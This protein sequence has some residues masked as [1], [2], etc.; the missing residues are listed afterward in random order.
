MSKFTSDFDM[1]ET[2]VLSKHKCCND[3][4]DFGKLEYLKMEDTCSCLNLL[5][6]KFCQC[7]DKVE[8]FYCYTIKKHSGIELLAYIENKCDANV[9]VGE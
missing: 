3:L 8:C 6:E 1:G 2:K 7:T 9:G 5:K 4:N